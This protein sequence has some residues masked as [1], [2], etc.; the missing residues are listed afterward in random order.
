MRRYLNDFVDRECF[1]LYQE[2]DDCDA[3]SEIFIE[4]T[5]E[6]IDSQCLNLTP[7]LDDG[8]K[9]LH[10]VLVAA[11]Y[12]PSNLK[13]RA[14]Y[15]IFQ[16]P[17]DESKAL[18]YESTAGT[19]EALAKEIEKCLDNPVIFGPLLEI[20]HV[21]LMIGYEIQLCFAINFDDVDDE[22][23]YRCQQLA[24]EIENVRDNALVESLTSG[25]L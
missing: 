7:G 8:Y 21:F 22:R 13:G 24:D 20:E 23:V 9:I 16:D 19:P 10:G 3:P 18:V 17:V 14:I 1:I 12:L 5:A 2:D 6:A 25:G 15:I 11:E 4:K